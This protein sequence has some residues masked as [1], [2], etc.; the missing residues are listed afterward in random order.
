[1]AEADG[2]VLDAVEKERMNPRVVERALTLTLAEAEILRDE[3]ARRREGLA[4]ELA[5]CEEEVEHLTSAIRR[6]WGF[7]STPHRRE[8]HLHAEVEWGL[9]VHG[10][11]NS[12]AA[13]QWGGT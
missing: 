2:A 1:M 9:R 8:A 7:G 6:G 12:A 5:K 4:T 11:R 3:T 13:T 10:T